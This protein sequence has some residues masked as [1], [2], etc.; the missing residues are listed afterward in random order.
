MHPAE[1]HER[2]TNGTDRLPMLSHHKFFRVHA[3]MQVYI[4]EWRKTEGNEHGNEWQG[5]NHSIEQ[6]MFVVEP[7][8]TD[9]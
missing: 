6:R 3:A 7:A 2:E 4:I 5:I 8:K 1:K 9:N